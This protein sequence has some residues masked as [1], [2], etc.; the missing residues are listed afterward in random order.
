MPLHPELLSCTASSASTDCTFF[1]RVLAR[2]LQGEG[3][4]KSCDRLI[5]NCP[6]YSGV[7]GLTTCDRP[8]PGASD[9]SISRS[10][11]SH[12][13]KQLYEPSH[14]YVPCE[15]GQMFFPYDKLLKLLQAIQQFSKHLSLYLYNV[16]KINDFVPCI[17]SF[18][19]GWMMMD[20]ICSMLRWSSLWSKRLSGSQRRSWKGGS[21]QVC[22]CVKVS[23]DAG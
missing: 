6:R 11:F 20:A 15:H 8:P 17:V 1:W 23:I 10:W 2:G 18:E 16:Q 19:A 22:R 7:V 3:C 13:W 5:G 12:W 21:W 14:S 9:Q 4:R